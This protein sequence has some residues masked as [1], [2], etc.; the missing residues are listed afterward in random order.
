[1]YLS[2]GLQITIFCDYFIGGAKP[3][4]IKVLFL[5]ATPILHREPY[6]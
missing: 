6:I 4:E 5:A 2:A 3:P 1:M